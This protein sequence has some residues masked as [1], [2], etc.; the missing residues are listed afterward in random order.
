MK[1]VGYIAGGGVWGSVFKVD[2]NDLVMPLA[3]ILGGAGEAHLSM[4]W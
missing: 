2:D 4:V 3:S 1:M